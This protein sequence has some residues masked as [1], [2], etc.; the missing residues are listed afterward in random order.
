[1]ESIAWIWSLSCL[2]VAVALVAL[3][4]RIGRGRAA[5]WLVVL[6]LV[7]LALEEPL[8]TLW[9]AIADPVADR[10]GMATLVTAPARAHV[11]DSAVLGL[12]FLMVLGGI[13][14]TAFRRG[15]RWAVAVL[16][17]GWLAV[18]AATMAT[19]LLVYG[20]GLSVPTPGGDA[21]G[22]GFGWEQLAV[23]LLAWAAGLWLRRRADR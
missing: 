2:A 19:T 17:L 22:A 20:R 12:A 13:A 8:L 10:D 1:M 11:L 18:V 15:Q 3:S 4:G 14:L 21:A 5:A 23:A 16:G 7:M 9:W 6:G